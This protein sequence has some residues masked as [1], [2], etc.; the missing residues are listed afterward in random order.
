MTTKTNTIKL[1]TSSKI[2]RRR[3]RPEHCDHQGIAHR[4][5]TRRHQRNHESFLQCSFENHGQ[6]LQWQG[7]K[8]EATGCS[9][10]ADPEQAICEKP[11]K[12]PTRMT[13]TNSQRG[14]LIQ[15]VIQN[16]S[17]HACTDARKMQRSVLFSQQRIG[18]S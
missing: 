3:Q 9:A 8:T 4:Q 13:K 6:M 12:F 15:P 14:W 16:A 10:L 1:L 18:Q 7:A 11:Q 5:T 2:P 17:F